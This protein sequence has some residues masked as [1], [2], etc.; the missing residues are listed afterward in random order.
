M[1]LGEDWARDMMALTDQSVFVVSAPAVTL[2]AA[3]IIPIANGL[4]TKLTLSSFVK[5]LITIVA[6]GVVALL[7]TAALDDGAA[8]FSF[9][10]VW[11]WLVGVI[12][13]LVSYARIYKP[14]RITSSAP[15][16]LLAPTVGIG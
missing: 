2:V 9:Q 4:L 13:S 15:D 1:R 10:M 8:A 16:G 11:T 12:V 6:N 7:A 14:L 3:L 5:G